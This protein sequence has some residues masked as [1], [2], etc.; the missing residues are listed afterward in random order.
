LNSIN[1]T[2]RLTRDAELT[3]T[4]N[5]NTVINFSIANDDERR[6]QNETWE[7]VVSFFNCVYWS[8]EGR[9]ARHLKKGKGVTITGQLRQDT[10][11]DDQGNNKS[12]VFINVQQVIPHAFEKT[13]QNQTSQPAPNSQKDKIDYENSDPEFQQGPGHDDVPF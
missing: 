13:D 11:K 8:K 7:A 4:K 3:L 5:N 10:W 2:G 1:I 9:M 12:K 6:K